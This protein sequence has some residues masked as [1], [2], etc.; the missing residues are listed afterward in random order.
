MENGGDCST[1]SRWGNRISADR[2][3]W[4]MFASQMH[5]SGWHWYAFSVQLFVDGAKPGL[6][7]L[8][9][10]QL[11][12]STYHGGDLSFPFKLF[13]KRVKVHNPS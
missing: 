6:F 11:Q 2:E 13:L 8:F 4:L 1:R 10:C 3:K 7:S 9:L 12:A 5:T